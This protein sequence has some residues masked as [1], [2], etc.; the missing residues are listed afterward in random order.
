MTRLV[1]ALLLLVGCGSS[2]PRYSSELVDVTRAGVAAEFW[3]SRIP[4][5]PPA[6]SD[7]E[8]SGRRSG[9]LA[10][11]VT[12]S[13]TLAR[14]PGFRCCNQYSPEYLLLRGADSTEYRLIHSPTMHLPSLTMATCEW[15]VWASL[16]SR[17]E[18]TVIG[19]VE[20]GVIRVEH[21]CR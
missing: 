2:E 20:G 6:Q 18:V 16:F 14:C 1:V 15:E 12:G 13:T 19:P 4:R 17:I 10:P 3:A 7:R 8:G 11:S 21:L 9:T 5:C